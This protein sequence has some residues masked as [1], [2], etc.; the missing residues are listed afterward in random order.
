[1]I[2]K[3]KFLSITGPK[4]VYKR[5][6]VARDLSVTVGTLTIAVNSLVKKGYVRRERSQKDRRVV[7]ISLTDRG[8][9]AYLHH[10]NFH[11]EMIRATLEG[12]SEEETAVL[13][14]ALS[15]LQEFFRGYG[16]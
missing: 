1:M 10:Q 2:E 6:A 13:V 7:L 8:D 9:R 16:K 12:L 5:Q 3:M 15:H 14:K 11:E 4:D